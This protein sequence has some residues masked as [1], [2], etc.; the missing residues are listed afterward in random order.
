MSGADVFNGL[1]AALWLVLAIG[2]GAASLRSPDRYRTT[3]LLAAAGFA[4][5]GVSDVLEILTSH[6]GMPWWLWAIKILCV[7]CLA[8]CYLGYRRIR[9]CPA[10]SGSQDRAPPRT[11]GQRGGGRGASGG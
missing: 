3:L 6:A 7:L 2:C 4:V 11:S 8:G 5:F 10:I 1:E 9:Q